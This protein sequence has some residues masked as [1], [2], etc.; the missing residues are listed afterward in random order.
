MIYLKFSHLNKAIFDKILIALL[1]L[2]ELAITCRSLLLV[3]SWT[4]ESVGK[5]LS[6]WERILSSGFYTIT[7]AQMQV[8][9]FEL[10]RLREIQNQPSAEKYHEFKIRNDKF[11]LICIL[12]TFIRGGVVVFSHINRHYRFFNS[13]AFRDS[14]ALFIALSKI[15]VEC[16]TFYLLIRSLR[17]FIKKNVEKNGKSKTL[18]FWVRFF[19]ITIFF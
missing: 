1:Y 3:L 18:S 15:P 8:L 13:N 12:V 16:C 5:E 11:K 2:L 6:L 17:F 7:W 14:V 19:I 9:I 10:N 4:F